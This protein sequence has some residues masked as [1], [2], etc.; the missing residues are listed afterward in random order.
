LTVRSRAHTFASMARPAPSEPDDEWIAVPRSVRFPVELTPPEGFDPAEPATW[1]RVEG[2]L[3]W[4]AG[5]LLYM[6]PCG[7]L[8]ALTVSDMV[9]TLGAWARSHPGFAVG[10]N[11]AGLRLGE[12]SRGADG[13]VFRRADMGPLTGK[14][15]RVPPVL[16]V[17]V[18]GPDEREAALRDKARWYLEMGVPVVWILLPECLEAVVIT[19]AGE[20]RLGMGDRLPEDSRLPDLAPAVAELFRQVAAAPVT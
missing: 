10:T 6:P 11:E 7:D 14:F 16:A 8:Q 18:S 5:R 20:T 4:V 12:D 3:E 19:P 2:R 9:F 15:V 13:A 17:E 1:P